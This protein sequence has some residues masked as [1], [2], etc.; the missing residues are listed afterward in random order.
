MNRAGGGPASQRGSAKARVDKSGRLP[1]LL[2]DGSPLAGRA[3]AG[4][5]M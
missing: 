3:L 4:V 1:S 5:W 2:D